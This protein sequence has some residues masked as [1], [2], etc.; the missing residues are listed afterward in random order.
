MLCVM[1]CVGVHVVSVVVVCGVCVCAVW[2][3][4]NPR[5]YFQNVTVYAGTRRTY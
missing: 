1:L 4:E 2:H 5:V 3:A